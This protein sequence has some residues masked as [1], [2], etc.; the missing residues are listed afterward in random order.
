MLVLVNEFGLSHLCAMQEFDF[1][2]DRADYYFQ[3][4]DIHVMNSLQFSQGLTNLATVIV[5]FKI[6][7][8]VNFGLH[9]DYDH[10]NTG[11]EIL[12]YFRGALDGNF[13]FNNLFEYLLWTFRNG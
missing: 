13:K 7:I 5:V 2:G 9:V 11:P 3:Y 4:L 8:F 10:S 6:G 1:V 12:F